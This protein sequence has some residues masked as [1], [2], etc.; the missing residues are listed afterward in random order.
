MREPYISLMHSTL[1]SPCGQDLT[2]LSDEALL[3]LVAHS[4]KQ[5]LLVLF[6]RHAAYLYSYI[7]EIIHNR[8]QRKQKPEI[9]HETF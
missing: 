8:I 1:H 3:E 6:D 2:T 9:L 4:E 5:A 7:L